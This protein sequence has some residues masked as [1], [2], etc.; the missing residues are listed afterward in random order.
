MVLKAPFSTLGLTKSC[1]S[2]EFDHPHRTVVQC[3][4]EPGLKQNQSFTRVV[5][6]SPAMHERWICS[7]P[8]QQQAGGVHT[9]CTTYL[10]VRWHTC[11]QRSSEFVRSNAHL[12]FTVIHEQA[13]QMPTAVRGLET[14]QLPYS[15]CILSCCAGHE[16]GGCMAGS[17]WA[18]PRQTSP[19]A[20]GDSQPCSAPS[21]V[22]VG[23]FRLA[24]SLACIT[25][26]YSSSAIIQL[27]TGQ[28]IPQ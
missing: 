14:V 5:Y 4:I 13:A 26:R 2:T 11:T 28:F 1:H 19:L 6:T 17:L 20:L 25:W 23:T 3:S 27:L 9:D 18:E 8:L 21:A 10:C 16:A 12:Y 24:P 7:K 22:G 15:A